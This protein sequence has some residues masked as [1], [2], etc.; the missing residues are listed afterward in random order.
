MNQSVSDYSRNAFAT[1]VVI[2][3]ICKVEIKLIAVMY[4]AAV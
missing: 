1:Y 4:Y 2:V 3:R